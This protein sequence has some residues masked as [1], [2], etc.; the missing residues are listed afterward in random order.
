MRH[1][2]DRHNPVGLRFFSL[3]EA[4]DLGAKPNR[5]VGRLDVGPSQILVAVLGIALAFFLAVTDFLT[6]DTPTVGSVVSYCRETREKGR[7]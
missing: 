2:F 1:R 7:C 4:L 3:V 6:P 5:E